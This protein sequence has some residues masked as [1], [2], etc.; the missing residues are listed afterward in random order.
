MVSVDLASRGLLSIV[1]NGC[2]IS[3]WY[4]FCQ[5]QKWSHS[6]LSYTTYSF[7][8]WCLR[9][10]KMVSDVAF[11][12]PSA[13]SVVFGN[14]LGHSWILIN[15]CIDRFLTPC[16]SIMRYNTNV[17]FQL[18]QISTTGPWMFRR[19]W[20]VR[21]E[22]GF[23]LAYC[24][25]GLHL[26]ELKPTLWSVSWDSVFGRHGEDHSG[27]DS[28][29]EGFWKL[30][31]NI[32]LDA[33]WGS[34]GCN[35]FQQSAPMHQSCIITWKLQA[36]ELTFKNESWIWLFLLSRPLKAPQRHYYLNNQHV[37]GV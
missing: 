13:S 24:W 33:P 25:A 12:R 4:L 2:K 5:F 23:K 7:L 1:R 35:G 19:S 6:C 15:V 26:K 37:V 17:K 28:S 14:K 18:I 8:L 22:R 31:K 21:S 10:F 9:M 29:N 34:W 16:L 30:R 11:S 32:F 27:D 36:M 3:R 20:N